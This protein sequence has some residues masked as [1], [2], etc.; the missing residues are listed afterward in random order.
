MLIIFNIAIHKYGALKIMWK[1][2]LAL[3]IIIVLVL[4]SCGHKSQKP[5]VD[6][7]GIPLVDGIDISGSDPIDAQ[8][9]SFRYEGRVYHCYLYFDNTDDIKLPSDLT[10]DDIVAYSIMDKD[11]LY[12]AAFSGLSDEEWLVSFWENGSK[13]KV[14]ANNIYI[15][16]KSDEINT[17]PD[18]LNEFKKSRE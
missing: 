3:L 10:I 15:V 7:T 9:F 6:L 12:H 5:S 1:R 8:E 13:G 4:S 2:V 11:V 17:T 14:L 16:W 18:W